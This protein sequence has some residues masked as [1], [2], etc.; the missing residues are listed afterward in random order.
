MIHT[1]RFFIAVDFDG[2]IVDNEYPNIGCPVP[3]AFEWLKKL[4]AKNADLIL[5]TWRSGDELRDAVKY[6]RIQGV[7][8]EFVN[9]NPLNNG[10]SPKAFADVYVDDTGVGCPLRKALRPGGQPVVNWRKVGPVLMH[11][12]RIHQ[13]KNSNRSARGFSFTSVFSS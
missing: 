5:W 7:D 6:C 11:M 2:T 12:L 10:R 1:R 9:R 3:H 13:R 8:F 4:K